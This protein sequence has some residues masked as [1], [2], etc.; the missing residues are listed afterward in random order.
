MDI[1]Q[2]GQFIAKLRKERDLTQQELAEA[3][4]VTDKA[5]SRWETGRGLPDAE[6]MLALSAF[7]GVTI[8]EL[9]LGK[10]NTGPETAKKEE[11]QLAVNCLKASAGQ[12]RMRTWIAVISAAL[13]LSVITTCAACSWLY[14]NVMGSADCVIAED[15][16]SFTLFGK[17]Y[18]SFDTGACSCIPG[19]VL[20]P[21]AQV[22][23][24]PFLGKLFFGDQILL[25]NGCDTIDFLYLDSEYDGSSEYYC[26]ESAF[27]KYQALLAAPMEK[28]AAEIVSREE[29]RYDVLLDEEIVAVLLSLTPAQQNT[30]VNCLVNRSKGE[31]AIDVSLKQESGPFRLAKGELL[32]KNGSYYWFDYA[33]IPV[34]QNN[35]DW[36]NIA[37]YDLPEGL[38]PKLDELFSKMY[39]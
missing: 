21:E 31:T 22:E 13:L 1:K 32:Y 15:Y 38:K 14:R 26:E 7:F 10:R 34:G 24:A 35:A 30:A 18:L 23:N 20:I 4:N 27:E 11:A 36:S 3:L 9:L 8:N 5:V 6:S 2:T 16:S 37:A 39:R 25:V 17:K 12:K 28:A 19:T 33:D 29:T